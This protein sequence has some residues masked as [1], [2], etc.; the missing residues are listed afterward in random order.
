L[1]SGAPGSG[2]GC[3]TMSIEEISQICEG[4]GVPYRR[5]QRMVEPEER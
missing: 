2:F 4:C 1:A 5:V 3:G